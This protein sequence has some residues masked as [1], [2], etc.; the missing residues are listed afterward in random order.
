MS[1]IE[2]IGEIERDLEEGGHIIAGHQP[3]V[4]HCSCR[5]VKDLLRAFKVMRE[6]AIESFRPM[7]V[8]KLVDGDIRVVFDPV[9]P[10]KIDGEFEK[11]LGEK[12]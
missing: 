7:Q 8:T 11:R 6:I 9:D 2:R 10:S 5:P 3:A 1:A 12:A 4:G